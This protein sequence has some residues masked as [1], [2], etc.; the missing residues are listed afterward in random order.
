MKRTI[1]RF[2]TCFLL[3]FLFAGLT[4]L[5]AQTASLASSVDTET[6]EEMIRDIMDAVDM[7]TTFEV[8]AA[9]I[10]NAAAATIK[11]K[12]YILYNP[13]FIAKLQQVTGSNRWAPISI[14]A[15]EIGHHIFGHT[16]KQSG[17]PQQT[18]LEADA[19][20]GFVLRRMGANL[21]DAQLAVRLASG[22]HATGTH[23]GRYD[24]LVA[25]ANGWS[26]ANE[27]I[28]GRPTQLLAEKYIAYDVHFNADPQSRYH[29]TTRNNL[30][31]VSASG[32]AVYGK[33]LSTDNADYPLA[34]TAGEN[35]WL[36]SNAGHI[37]TSAGKT[38]GYLKAHSN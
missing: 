9:R 22:R 24:R 33:L 26:K 37:V 17:N 3:S 5:N 35:V 11:G 29:I 10:P 14:L 20:S 15:H 12:R 18:E 25:I 6:A 30:V 7:E 16:L 36:V 21:E 32:L 4:A 31:K 1:I 19:F 27:Q 38:L 34:L 13:A 23:P 8:R 2:I 28:T